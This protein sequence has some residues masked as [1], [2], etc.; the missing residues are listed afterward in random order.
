MIIMKGFTDNVGD[1]HQNLDL[2]KMRAVAVA[3][4]FEKLSGVTKKKIITAPSKG[5]Q[6]VLQENKN[7]EKKEPKHRRVE[8]TIFVEG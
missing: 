3:E 6:D 5:E 2:G 7:L 4:M 1:E 8:V